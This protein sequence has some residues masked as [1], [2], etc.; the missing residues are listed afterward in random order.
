[1]CHVCWWR[2]VVIV[3][4]WVEFLLCNPL[5][6]A[7]FVWSGF[8]KVMQ[9]SPA[10]VEAPLLGHHLG[11]DFWQRLRSSMMLQSRWT[12][13]VAAERATPGALLFF[14]GAHTL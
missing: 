8:L 14:V 2:V 6:W 1:M 7:V 4:L 11:L 12:G 9:W 13:V 3:A 10:S 5:L